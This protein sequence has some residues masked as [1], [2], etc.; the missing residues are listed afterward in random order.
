VARKGDDGKADLERDLLLCQF[1]SLLAAATHGRGEHLGQRHRHERGRG[2][3]PVVDVLGQGEVVPPRP[4]TVSHEP[5]RVDVDQK[6]HGAAVL[7]RLRVQD[8]GG[9]EGELGRVATVWI[10]VQQ[11]PKIRRRPVGG[12]EREDHDGC[13][14]T[15]NDALTRA[16]LGKASLEVAGF[17]PAS[18]GV[19]I[20]LLRAQPALDCR[21]RH[22]CRRLCRPVPNE[23][24]SAVSWCCH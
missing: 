21:G 16:F 14:R 9:A 15:S 20:G 24:S 8:V 18:S 11:I 1:G 19:S 2:E 13:W 22:H 17:E 7:C 10:F 4:A 12:R 6:R 23:M 3:G 5:N